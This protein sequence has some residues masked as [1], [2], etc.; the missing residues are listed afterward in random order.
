[1]TR[2]DEI[3]T[4]EGFRFDAP[5]LEARTG[6][7]EF[8][9]A[10]T[11]YF[12]AMGIPLVRGRLFDETDAPGRPHVALISRS[13]AEKQWP[14]KDPLGRFIQFGNMDGDLTG[15]RIVGVVG[16]VRELSPEAA[17]GPMIY[18]NARQRPAAMRW[19]SVIARGPGLPALA[20]PVRRIMREELPDSPYE[21]TTV[22]AGL[23]RAVGSR[24]FNLW[25]IGAFAASALGL[26]MLGVYGLVAYA[27]AQRRREMGIRVALGA[28]PSSLVRLVLSHAAWLT[29]VGSAAGLVLALL[30]RRAVAGMLFGVTATD[31][32]VLAAVAALML[33]AAMAASYLPARRILKQAPGRSLRD[34]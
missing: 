12:E 14:G 3:A 10:S 8:R 11:G 27:V 24:R 29:L 16:D 6:E 21:L 30:A 32:P 18:V 15:L 13:L 34:L 4:F 2:V 20:G 5:E 7:A 28:E 17:P 9:I 26:A 33:A 1:M 23:D 22:G 25:L 19:F 31:P